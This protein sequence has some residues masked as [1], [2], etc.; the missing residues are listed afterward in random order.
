M[1]GGGEITKYFLMNVNCSFRHNRLSTV[2]HEFESAE[3]LN[4]FDPTE[5]L[6]IAIQDRHFKNPG[7]YP[8]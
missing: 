8:A 6:E 2:V 5:I 7:S 3:S 1:R 4:Q